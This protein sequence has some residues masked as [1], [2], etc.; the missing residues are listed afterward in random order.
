MPVSTGCAAGGLRIRH[1]ASQESTVASPQWTSCRDPPR[2]RAACAQAAL[3]LW[4]IAE[5]GFGEI[6]RG[7]L[8][9]DRHNQYAMH[10]QGADVPA[11]VARRGVFRSAARGGAAARLCSYCSW[12]LP[13]TTATA[14]EFGLATQ[15]WSGVGKPDAHLLPTSLGTAGPRSKPVVGFLTASWNA[16]RQ[17][18]VWLDFLRCLGTRTPR[19]GEQLWLLN[20]AAKRSCSL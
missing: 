15:A 8:P 11:V 5:S 6:Y 13:M 20:P 3:T 18:T 2:D 7:A 4:P 14:R 17:S 1:A 12:V 10:D 16:D 9:N 19:A